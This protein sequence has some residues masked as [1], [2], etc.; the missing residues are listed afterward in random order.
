VRR[1][2]ALGRTRAVVVVL[3][4]GRSA[5]EEAT[6]PLA[7]SVLRLLPVARRVRRDTL[8]RGVAVWR[9]RFRVRGWNGAQQLPVV[10]TRWVLEDVRRRHGDVP[11][12]LVGH[13]M[14]GRTA[15]HVADDR[16]VRAVVGLAP[17]L[18]SSD[19]VRASDGSRLALVH[20]DDDRMTSLAATLSYAERARRAGVPVTTV[21]LRRGEHFLLRRALLWHGLASALV[22]D[23]LAGAGVGR[24]PRRGRAARALTGGQRLEL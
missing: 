15:V 24:A 20:G 12:V 17:W 14:G 6:S 5:S 23:A 18:S 10:D 13:S 3:H 8:L 1:A 7:L 21:V 11:V 9:V 16:S 19:P 22:R 4:G 2:R